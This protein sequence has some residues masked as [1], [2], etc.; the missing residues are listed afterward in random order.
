MWKSNLNLETK[1]KSSRKPIRIAVALL[2]TAI[3]MG[4]WILASRSDGLQTS[5]AAGG[6]TFSAS[7]AS[8][9]LINTQSLPGMT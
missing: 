6:G 7:G 4:A 1:K 9:Q 8:I 2:A 3:A 5:Y